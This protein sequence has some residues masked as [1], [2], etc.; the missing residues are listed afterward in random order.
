MSLEWIVLLFGGVPI[1]C[2]LCLLVLV[3]FAESLTLYCKLERIVSRD[4]NNS[5]SFELKLMK[6]FSFRTI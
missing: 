6:E 4:D 1:E 3:C 5:D 2:C